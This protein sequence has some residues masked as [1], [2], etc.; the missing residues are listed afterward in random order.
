MASIC[1]R[2]S[3]T[4]ASGCLD[5][6]LVG[7]CIPAQDGTIPPPAQQPKRATNVSRGA[8]GGERRA[9]GEICFH[10]KKNTARS[11]LSARSACNASSP[12]SGPGGDGLLAV[13]QGGDHGK[14]DEAFARGPE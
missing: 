8:R 7:S 12:S 13:V 10:K 6:G 11:A 14:A 5:S 9:S 2:S 4:L 3:G 1:A